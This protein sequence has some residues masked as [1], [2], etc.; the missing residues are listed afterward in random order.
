MM[1]SWMSVFVIRILW[2]GRALVNAER[3]NAAANRKW[4]VENQASA[5]FEAGFQVIFLSQEFRGI[6][7][8]E[9]KKQ[10]SSRVFKRHQS[11][12]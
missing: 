6:Y 8:V 4:N 2:Q 12:V 9:A 5:F 10:F 3:G 1:F 7:Q 11:V